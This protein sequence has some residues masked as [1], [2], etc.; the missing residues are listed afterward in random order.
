MKFFSALKVMIRVSNINTVN[1]VVAID[2]II[3]NDGLNNLAPT[4]KFGIR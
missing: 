4:N 2:D 1:D 3:Y